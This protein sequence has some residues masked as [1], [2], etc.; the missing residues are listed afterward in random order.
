MFI[1]IILTSKSYS[2]TLIKISNKEWFAS[3]EKNIILLFFNPH[4]S[5]G[6]AHLPPPPPGKHGSEDSHYTGCSGF[7]DGHDLSD[8]TSGQDHTGPIVVG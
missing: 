8:P 7:P 5:C 2:N 6:S 3:W 4:L 1:F